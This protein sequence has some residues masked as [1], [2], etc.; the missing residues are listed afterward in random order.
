[1]KKKLLLIFM[2]LLFLCAC[3]E[4]GKEIEVQP[5][6]VVLELNAVNPEVYSHIEIKDLIKETNVDDYKNEVIDTNNVG[7]QNVSIL[8]RR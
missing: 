6:E 8:P 7:I 2:C 4:E 5:Q 1:M 3:K